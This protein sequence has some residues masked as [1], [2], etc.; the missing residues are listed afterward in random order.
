MFNEING[1]IIHENVL[2][3]MATLHKILLAKVFLFS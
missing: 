2:H 1:M 3:G